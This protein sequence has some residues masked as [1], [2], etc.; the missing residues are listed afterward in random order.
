MPKLWPLAASHARL[1]LPVEDSSNLSPLASGARAG[2]HTRLEIS[3]KLLDTELSLVTALAVLLK[4]LTVD[5][6]R[7][8]GLHADGRLL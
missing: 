1:Q 6:C 8:L 7:M 5:L 4:V 2:S 3:R